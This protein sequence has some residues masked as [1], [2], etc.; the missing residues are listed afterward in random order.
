M[1]KAILVSGDFGDR[2]T[3]SDEWAMLDDCLS[4]GWKVV[5]TEA[6]HASFGGGSSKYSNGT[7]LVI[8]EKK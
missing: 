8:V 5:H 6:F 7:M 2:K 1:Q 4:T 3:P